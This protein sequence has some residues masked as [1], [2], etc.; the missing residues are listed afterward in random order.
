MELQSLCAFVSLPTFKALEEPF[1]EI[2]SLPASTLHFSS[3][4]TGF[5]SLEL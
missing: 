4:H 3:P 1:T 5:I 2:P